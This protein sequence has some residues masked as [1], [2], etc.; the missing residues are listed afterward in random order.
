LQTVSSSVPAISD[1]GLLY[2]CGI[3]DILR[4]Y[5]IEVRP[6]TVTTNR[7]YGAE[8][9]GNYGMG[10]P[11]PS[12]WAGQ[13]S[14]FIDSDQERTY[15]E[16]SLA[17]RTG[18]IGLN[19]PIYVA[20]MM[21]MI[22]SHF[23][24]P[25]ESQVRPDVRPTQRV[26]LINLLAMVGSRETIPFLWNVFDRDP[27]PAVRSACAEA[28]GRIGVDPTGRSF[29]SYYYLLSPNNPN[30]DPHLVLA[31][32]SSIARICRFGGP[33]LAHEGIRV[34]RYFSNLPSVPNRV[35]L[36]IRA[37]IDGLFRDGLDQV[38]Q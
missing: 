28:I 4:V 30:V 5:K 34:L 31:A 32:S 17:V 1:E 18:Q 9:E 38:M 7:Y 35:R 29:H 10:N 14:R 23:G 19:E 11:P 8:P 21:E 27:E 6:R 33:P 22:S 3:D 25:N 16:I 15:E 20:Y 2:A 13:R 37:E 24:T 26:R 12:P 36:Q